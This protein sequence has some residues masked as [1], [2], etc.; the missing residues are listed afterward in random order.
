MRTILIPDTDSS[1]NLNLHSQDRE[2]TRSHLFAAL[3]TPG[4]D[5]VKIVKDYPRHV[6]VSAGASYG[7]SISV[8]YPEALV[9]EIDSLVEEAKERAKPIRAISDRPKAIAA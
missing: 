1:F 4:L 6:K 8:F 3:C 2:D 7:E 9:D 5:A